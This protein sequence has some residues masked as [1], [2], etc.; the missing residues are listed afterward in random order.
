MTEY[1]EITEE[2]F[3][4]TED[5]FDYMGPIADSADS[6]DD[7]D[8]ADGYSP[9]TAGAREDDGEPSNNDDDDGDGDGDDDDDD[10]DD[11][12]GTIRVVRV[13]VLRRKD[14]VQ[15][16]AESGEDEDEDGREPQQERSKTKSVRAAAEATTT[17]R[18]S[19]QQQQQ[20]R[21]RQEQQE[22]DFDEGYTWRSTPRSSAGM[23]KVV[24]RPLGREQR[25]YLEDAS[26]TFFGILEE[27]LRVYRRE[28]SMA[29]VEEIFQFA[30]SL[31]THRIATPAPSDLLFDILFAD[32]FNGYDLN[33]VK[34]RITLLRLITSD[35]CD[36][37]V[38]ATTEMH[39]ALLNNQLLPHLLPPAPKDLPP[40][41]VHC[42][43][44]GTALCS[45]FDLITIERKKNARSL[46]LSRSHTS[47]PCFLSLA[48]SLFFF[49][50]P[51]HNSHRIDIA[52]PATPLHCHVS[53]RPGKHP[54][55]RVLPDVSDCGGHALPLELPR[56]PRL[57]LR[58]RGLPQEQDCAPSSR[59]SLWFVFSHFSLFQT[60]ASSL[61]CLFTCVQRCCAVNT[62]EFKRRCPFRFTK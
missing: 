12:D 45:T 31:R 13:R 61:M 18:T 2:P 51:P 16:A 62:S 29:G 55:A 26:A 48:C 58:R 37:L 21:Q 32:T 25:Q 17:A 44:C 28:P 54:C 15:A 30:D 59:R 20:Q 1:T 35:F 33:I 52:R 7:A 19:Q 14:P 9:A 22:R 36:G 53:E 5:D 57:H 11:G 34:N 38:D 10:D 39:T 27:M 50:S 56:A 49:A 4:D 24:D 42:S 46:F 3:E 60:H 43:A 47:A 8:G 40:F 41:Y 6:A 23:F